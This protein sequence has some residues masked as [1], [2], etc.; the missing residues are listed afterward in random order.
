MRKNYLLIGVTVLIVAVALAV[1][2]SGCG[3]EGLMKLQT[4]VIVKVNEDITLQPNQL[5]PPISLLYGTIELEL[6]G[7]NYRTASISAGN[8]VA[9]FGNLAPGLYDL[10]GILYNDDGTPVAL[11]SGTVTGIEVLIAD[12]TEVNLTIVE[13]PGDGALQLNLAWEPDLVESPSMETILTDKDGTEIDIS[14]GLDAN[15]NLVACTTDVLVDPLA[16][17]WHS[18]VCKLWDSEAEVHASGFAD[19]VRIVQGQLTTGDVLMHAQLSTGG[20]DVNIDLDFFEEIPV[21][22]VDPQYDVDE[23]HMYL[24]S[25]PFDL[26]VAAGGGKTFATG[27]F[28]VQGDSRGSGLIF[29]IDPL[30]YTIDDYVRVDFI[31]WNVEGEAGH[32][33]WTLWRDSYSTADYA[34]SGSVV[35][36]TDPWFAKY[37]GVVVFDSDGTTVLVHASNLGPTSEGGHPSAFDVGIPDDMERD[38]ILMVYI[39]GTNDGLWTT[40][41]DIIQTYNAGVPVHV[42][43]KL[44]AGLFA[45]N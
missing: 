35:R 8:T 15:I 10:T 9:T 39:D 20:I 14:A 18:L 30:D 16:Y 27:V 19:L 13:T 26:E 41:G 17:G 33:A 29:N 5:Y 11:G 24:N 23:I 43:P 12:S 4:K 45:F 32:R 44:E 42:P 21:E 28:Y 37:Y 25:T 6:D 38:V 7:P 2:F 34:V 31:G 36:G 22:V 1:G 3:L 40:S